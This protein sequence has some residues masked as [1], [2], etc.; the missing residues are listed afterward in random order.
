[1]ADLKVLRD[2]VA[3]AKSMG[4]VRTGSGPVGDV[5]RRA[6]W[7]PQASK[8]NPN[9]SQQTLVEF[10]EQDRRPFSMGPVNVLAIAEQETKGTLKTIIDTLRTVGGT[11][12][13]RTPEQLEIVRKYLD[14]AV[15]LATTILEERMTEQAPAAPPELPDVANLSDEQKAALLAQLTKPAK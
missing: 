4:R 14:D 13:K 1:M 7:T 6:L 5:V 11:W 15:A 10:A 3:K 12:N 8:R 2:L 9:P